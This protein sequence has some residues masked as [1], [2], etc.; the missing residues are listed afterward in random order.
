M[1][2]GIRG[3][4]GL[5]QIRGDGGLTVKIARGFRYV[6]LA[7]ADVQFRTFENRRQRI[8]VTVLIALVE[9]FENPRADLLLLL[10]AQVRRILPGG[11]FRGRQLA[12]ATA[13]ADGHSQ[14]EHGRDNRLT[15]L[16]HHWSSSWPS[17]C[18]S[19]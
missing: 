1:A 12:F 11:G 14:R 17:S 9:R 18:V 2:A 16:P 8:S 4:H 6:Q 19:V 3:D 10:G 7:G 15:T 5:G 13:H